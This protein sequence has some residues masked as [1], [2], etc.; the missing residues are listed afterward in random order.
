MPIEGWSFILVFS[1]TDPPGPRR[2]ASSAAGAKRHA[3]RRTPAR[4]LGHIWTKNYMHIAHEMPS[5]MRSTLVCAQGAQR[6]K[7]RDVVW[8]PQAQG[9]VRARR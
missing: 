3:T 4:E 1:R 2:R 9:S 6:A 7:T 8:Q 5:R